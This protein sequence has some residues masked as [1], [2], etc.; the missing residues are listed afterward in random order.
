MLRSLAFSPDGLR[1]VSVSDDRT[2]RVWNVAESSR[3]GPSAHH[4]P[5]IKTR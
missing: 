5:D 1:L 2:V 3:G 4:S